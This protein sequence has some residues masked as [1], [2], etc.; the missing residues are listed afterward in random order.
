MIQK[1]FSVTPD[2]YASAGNRFANYIVD[3][4]GYYILAIIL[5]VILGLLELIGVRLL[6]TVSS[7]G[8]IG[9]LLFTICLWIIYFFIFEFFT[10]KTLGKLITKTIVVMEDGSK[11]TFQDVFIRSLCRFIPFEAFSFLGSE[12]RG[13][14]DSMSNTYVVNE[15]KF[16]AKMESSNELDQIGVVQEE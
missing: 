12:V 2:L 1:K 4:I 7:M 5:G 8:T 10:Q 16:K 13:W 9:D 14:H 3:L 6:E 15:A 11:P